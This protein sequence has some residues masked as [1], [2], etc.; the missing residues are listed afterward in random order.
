MDGNIKDINP[1]VFLNDLQDKAF[2]T[3]AA[4]PGQK[5]L[6]ASTSRLG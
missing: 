3:H 5:L 1:D 4:L 6:S 2:S